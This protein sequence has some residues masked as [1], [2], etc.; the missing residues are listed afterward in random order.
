VHCDCGQP[1]V[2]AHTRALHC[3]EH[4]DTLNRVPQHGGADGAV[5][6]CDTDGLWHGAP[7]WWFGDQVAAARARPLGAATL[8]RNDIAAVEAY[9][10]TDWDVPCMSNVRGNE[11][12]TGH[13]P[14]DRLADVIVVTPA[15]W[16]AFASPYCRPCFATYIHRSVNANYPPKELPYVALAWVDG[17]WVA[18][19]S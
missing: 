13:G 8:L 10:G 9:E 2:A 14:T 18:A 7:Q 12:S 1:A 4:L 16:G 17:S 15:P 6:W 5:A 11:R 19:D 3:V